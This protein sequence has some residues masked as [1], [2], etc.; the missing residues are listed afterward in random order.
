MVQSTKIQ[1]YTYRVWFLRP[2]KRS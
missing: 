1:Y 2:G